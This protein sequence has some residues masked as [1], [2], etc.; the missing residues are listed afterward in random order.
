MAPTT[1]RFR[2]A[3]VGRLAVSII[4]AVVVGVGAA[5]ATPDGL[6]LDIVVATVSLSPVVGLVVTVAATAYFVTAAETRQIL[7]TTL[8]ILAAVTA[9]FPLLN[10]LLPWLYP[11]LGTAPPRSVVGMGALGLLFVLGWGATLVFALAGYA[12]DQSAAAG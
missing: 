8:Y 7:V 12:L 4:A 2:V 11:S 9:A 6:V 5:I 10:G 1:S 3:D